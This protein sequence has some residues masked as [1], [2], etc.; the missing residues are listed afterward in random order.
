MLAHGAQGSFENDDG[1]DWASECTSAKS[2]APVS[3]ALALVSRINRL[4][5][6]MVD[7]L[8]RCRGGRSRARPSQP[9]ATFAI[10]R[11]D[12]P[13]TIGTV[14][15]P[16]SECSNGTHAG[17]E[18]RDFGAGKIVVC[19]PTQQMDGIHFGVAS[20]VEGTIVSDLWE[21]TPT[22]SRTRRFMFSRSRASARRFR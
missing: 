13:S 21:L 15:R 3:A 18:R 20:A 7:G 8:S 22:A 17:R 16:R 9:Q 6:L 11:L 2:V 5:R 14:G 10:A 1:L 19:A 12:H 4:K